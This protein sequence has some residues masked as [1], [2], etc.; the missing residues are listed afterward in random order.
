MVHVNF[1][2][3]TNTCMVTQSLSCSLE[4]LWEPVDCGV[5]TCG[6]LWTGNR[7]SLMWLQCEEMNTPI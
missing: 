5:P 3:I 1:V 6:G 7:H 2:R 4:G